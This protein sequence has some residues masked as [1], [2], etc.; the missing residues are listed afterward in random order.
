MTIAALSIGIT[1]RLVR[2]IGARRTLLPGLLMGLLGL[3][4]LTRTPVNASYWVDVLPALLAVGAG[5]GLAFMPTI[6]L[7]MSA[8]GTSDAGVASGLVNVSQQLPA[9]AGVAVLGTI[10]TRHTTGLLLDGESPRAALTAGYHVG[11]AVAAI[12][13][14]LSIAVATIAVRPAA[15]TRGP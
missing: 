10:A 7:A 6:M 2:R 4:F 8:V 3:A 5:A 15:D 13:V 11:F 14:A 9:A 1:P 12:S